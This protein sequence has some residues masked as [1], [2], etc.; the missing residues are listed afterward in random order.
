MTVRDEIRSG[1]RRA[2]G[3]VLCLLTAFVVVDLGLGLFGPLSESVRR[4][5]GGGFLVLLGT[6]GVAMLRWRAIQG[7][8]IGAFGLAFLLFRAPPGVLA[9]ATPLVLLLAAS[10]SN[11]PRGGIRIAL[12]ASFACLS[13]SLWLH[14]GAARPFFL[15]CAEGLG[16]L[17]RMAGLSSAEL[18]ATQVGI[19]SLLGL[20]VGLA[21][22]DL[23]SDRVR[24]ALWA[25]RL[26]GAPL[27]ASLVTLG[28]YSSLP[29]GSTIRNHPSLLTGGH[30]VLGA[31]GEPVGIGGPPITHARRTDPHDHGEQE[32]GSHRDSPSVPAHSITLP[33]DPRPAARRMRVCV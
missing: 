3:E 23:R 26:I 12:A 9:W 7:G 29:D 30:H 10:I 14:L 2:I 11:G 1:P 33:V 31:V 4:T 5:A 32:H 15:G 21:L 27:I 16:S 17:A 28:V 19:P 6:L 18:G 13:S 25:A 8:L 22:A 20:A 24:W